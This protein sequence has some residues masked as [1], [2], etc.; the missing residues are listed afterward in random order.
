MVR[1][2]MGINIEIDV[3]NYDDIIKEEKGNNWGFITKIPIVGDIAKSKVDTKIESEIAK[4]LKSKLPFE[5]QRNI[6][7]QL[8]SQLSSKG[9]NAIV[10]CKTKITR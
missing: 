4:G 8:N 3:N 9:V 1:V 6:K 7:N 2:K 10:N 5:L